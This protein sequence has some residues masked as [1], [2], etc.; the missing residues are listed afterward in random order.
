[1]ED[2]LWLEASSSMI[3]WCLSSDFLPKQLQPLDSMVISL[4]VVPAAIVSRRIPLAELS[5]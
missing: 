3:I 5:L 2:Q 1:M 4:E